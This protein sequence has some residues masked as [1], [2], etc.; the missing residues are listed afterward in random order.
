MTIRL[1]LLVFAVVSLLGIGYVSWTHLG[2][3]DRV[4]GGAYVVHADFAEAGGIFTN[5]SVSYRG[6]PIGKVA[7]VRLHGSGV[8]VDLQIDGAQKIPVET[9]A[10][11]ALRS[12]VGEQYVDLRPS[13]ADGPFLKAGDVIPVERT[14]T[15]LPVETLLSNLNALVESVDPKSLGIF[16][17]ELGTG[18]EGNET[19]LRQ[20]LDANNLLLEDAVRYL[21]ETKALIQDGQTVLKTQLESAQAIKAWAQGLAQLAARL[22]ESDG[23]LRTLLA[24]GPPAATELRGL[25]SDLDPTVGM[26]LGNLIS[27]NGVAARRVNGIEMILVTYPLVV[28]GGFT[29]M[30]GDGTAHLGLVVNANDPPPCQYQQSGQ[31]TRCTQAEQAQG[32]SVRGTNNIPRPGGPEPSPAPLPPR[33]QVSP[34]LP[35]GPELSA[36]PTIA[37]Y[38]PVTGLVIGP[39]GRPLLFGGDGGQAAFAGPQSWKLLLFS[40]VAP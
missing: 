29:V 28:S 6:V 32:S 23:D 19:A 35:P 17:D 8:R 36:G 40:G 12:A 3:G 2:L 27:V 34:S 9:A 26:L 7:A 21:P 33:A 15:P 5:A 25:L 22:R 4:F 1:K 18:F 10:V 37:G 16:L 38:D 30:P 20:L 39:D 11:V 14:S 13:T 31:N 24:N